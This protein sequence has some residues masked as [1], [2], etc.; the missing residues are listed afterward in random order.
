MSPRSTDYTALTMP[1]ATYHANGAPNCFRSR[2]YSRAAAMQNSGG[3]H[4]FDRQLVTAKLQQPWRASAL[5]S[6]GPAQTKDGSADPK[7]SDVVEASVPAY[8]VSVAVDR[9]SQLAVATAGGDVIEYRIPQYVGAGNC[10]L[11]RLTVLLTLF[12]CIW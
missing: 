1:A 5:H 11:V 7:G 2:V 8:P 3:R 9:P 10:L 6:K 12:W 4:K